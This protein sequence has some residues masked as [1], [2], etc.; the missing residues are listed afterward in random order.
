MD[1]ASSLPMIW[2]LDGPCLVIAKDRAPG[3]TLSHYYHWWGRTW[4]NTASSLPVKGD[5][6]YHC[7]CRVT[8]MDL[9]SSLPVMGD[10]NGPCLI[11]IH[12]GVPDRHCLIITSDRGPGWT[13][14]PHCQWWVTWMDPLSP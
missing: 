6:R 9:T 8:W 12:V 14:H 4:I 5:R 7:Q 2:H 11:V 10:Q 13:L 3:W 1:L